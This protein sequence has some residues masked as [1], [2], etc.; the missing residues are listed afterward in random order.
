[1]T[2]DVAPPSPAAAPQAVEPIRGVLRLAE[3]AIVPP[4]SVLYLMAR[5]LDGGPPVAA[6]KLP[7]GPFP[8]PFEIGPEDAMIAGRPFEGP[9]QLTARI[10]RDGDPLTRE[11]GEPAASFGDPV[12]PG[13]QG[14]ELI[15]GAQADR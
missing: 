10:D 9:V 4:G 12:A 2:P 1:M 6:R 13:S 8:M 3:G 11:P 7:P 14:I 15:L 5:A